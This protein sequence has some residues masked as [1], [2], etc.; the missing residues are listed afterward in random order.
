MKSVFRREGDIK[1]F[2]KT[3]PVTSIIIIINTIFLLVTLLLGGFEISVLLRLGAMSKEVYTEGEYFRLLTYGFLHADFMHFFSNMIIGVVVLSSGLERVIGSKKFSIIYFATLI[4]VSLLTLG[5]TYFFKDNL[6][7]L[8]ASGAIF[9]VLGAL[10]YI[11][12]NRPELIPKQEIQ[13]IRVLI[14]VQI[15]FTFITPGVSI[16][17]HVGGLAIGFLL[18]FLVIRKP[19]GYDKKTDTYD[20]TVH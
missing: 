16:I 15:V 17:G 7:S 11:T 9:G 19:N 20:F 5:Y 18:S 3:S 10:L 13:S 1:D 8:G 12:I 2:Y 4:M 6:V 14:I